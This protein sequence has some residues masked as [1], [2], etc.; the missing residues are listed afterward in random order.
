MSLEQMAGR[1]CVCVYGFEY[2]NEVN[3]LPVQGC[4]GA[5]L[6]YP[7]QRVLNLCRLERI[8]KAIMQ[9]NMLLTFFLCVCV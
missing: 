7:A 2:I 5:A 1:V 4:S 3:K 6:L 9:P 8:L